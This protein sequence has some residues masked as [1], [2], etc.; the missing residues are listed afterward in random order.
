MFDLNGSEKV[1][2]ILL[3]DSQKKLQSQI[4]KVYN[5]DLASDLQF[6]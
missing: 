4:K 2:S 3:A 5:D 1:K 6:Q